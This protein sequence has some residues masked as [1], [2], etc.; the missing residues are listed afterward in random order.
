MYNFPSSASKAS[1]F[2][3]NITRYD[4]DAFG[5][6]YA[7]VKTPKNKYLNISILQHRIKSK[8]GGVV[9]M[10]VYIGNKR[11]EL[12]KVCYY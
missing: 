9:T 10:C 6:F 4:N 11:F 5:F 8:N 3:R 12:L 2:K 1:R 7:K